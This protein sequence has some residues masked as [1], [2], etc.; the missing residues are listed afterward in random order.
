M[1]K[2]RAFFTQSLLHQFVLAG[3]LVMCA[4]AIVVG[5]WVANRIE[6]G[7]VQNSATSAALYMESYISPLS[8]ELSAEDGLSDP[9]RTALREIFLG[10]S[11]GDRVV[12]YKIWKKGGRIIEAS[13]PELRNQVFNPSDDQL[14]AWNGDIA[15]S[16]QDLRDLEDAAE[17][18]M[19]IPLLEVYSPV[20]EV[21]TGEIVAV[22]EFYERADSLARELSDAR[23]NGWFIVFAVF[24]ISGLLL[25][26]IVKSGS[27]LI[28]QQQAALKTQLDE[29]QRISGQN[30]ELK[31]S[32]A[33]AAQRSTAQA[34]RVMQRIGQDLHDGVAQHLSLASL[35]F[36]EAEPT[37]QETAKTVRVAL[38]AA[39]T[40]LRAISRGLALP[41]LEE[42]TP[43]KT[44]K[45]AV[46]DH[47]NAFNSA[48]HLA[49][50][51]LPK[52]AVSYSFK[53]CIYRFLQEALA[54]AARHARADTIDVHINTDAM[55]LFVKVADT[56]IGF[57]PDT[58]MAVRP[59]G[60]QGLLGLRD[61][62]AT[63]GGRL[64]VWSTVG[65]GAELTLALPYGEA[66]T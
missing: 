32:I 6:Q 57:E 36:E 62:A 39:M 54:N 66:K 56:G 18:A 23:R 64:E 60:G 4:A 44:I 58:E 2:V 49:P 28:D 53:L 50:F 42:L 24:A 12:S 35:R 46:Q 16:F 7:V 52:M 21:W 22:A 11:L 55:T 33:A 10:T 9:A 1:N 15:A 8:Q 41:D 43:T 13:N 26:G 63:L 30:R 25:F 19:G 59:D 51:E 38:D 61:R 34:D 37:K 65:K 31:D 45:R 17:A 27:R 5:S 47:K 40:E 14:A 29:T 3:G 48:V 20:R